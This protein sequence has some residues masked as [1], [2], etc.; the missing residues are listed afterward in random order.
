VPRD[1]NRLLTCPP[2]VPLR[3]VAGIMAVHEVHAVVLWD[4]SGGGPTIVTDLDLVA[5]AKEIDSADAASVAG[6]PPTVAS[7]D[8]L[9]AAAA[10]MADSG[11]SHVLVVDPESGHPTGMVSTLDVAAAL[12]GRNPRAARSVRP[13][14]A[15]PA[16][17]TSR[18]DRVPV[19][20]AM[21]VGVFTC[22]PQAG[23][24]DVASILVDRHVHCV[25]VTGT[26]GPAS[27]KFI[28]DLTIARAAASNAD[29]LAADLVGEATWIAGDA[30]LEEASELMVRK[31]AAHLLVRGDHQPIGV[32]S[33]LDV[34]AVLA[35][36]ADDLGVAGAWRR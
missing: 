16:I 20:V 2:G 6:T 9:R 19:A 26:P 3:V 24:R 33:T 8:D 15:R 11:H 30:T 29:A 25:A 18:L 36:G 35:V 13:R 17:S 28:T 32:L 31:S 14:P 4:G 22:P 34:I 1:R 23:L 12:A 10:V 7:G 27:W 5:A 21:H